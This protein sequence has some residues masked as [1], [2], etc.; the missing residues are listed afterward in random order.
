MDDIK[1]TQ[2]ALYLLPVSLSDGAVDDVLPRRNLE[3][4]SC[5]RY[6]IVENV[7]EARRF[8]RR[9]L[10][11]ADI[12]VLEFVELNRHT[13]LNEVTHWLEP[14]RRGEAMGLMSD[15]GCPGVAD[16]G[17]VVVSAARREG[18]KVVPLVG[19]SSI[20]LG[21]MGSGFN[22]QGFCFHGYLPIDERERVEA[23]RRLEIESSHRDMTQIFIETPYRNNRMLAALVST[24]RDDTGIC[25]ACELT[26]R[27]SETIVSMPA[28]KWRKVLAEAGGERGNCA[29]GK[30]DFDKRPAVFLI[31]AGRT[32]QADTES[33]RKNAYRSVDEKRRGRGR[34]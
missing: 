13:D 2:P 28:G 18:L 10:P 24:L 21:L 33:G 23:L 26:S 31:Y 17:A 3:I 32:P 29:G 22:G 4:M 27:E 5:L 9:A 6:F 1:E 16:P 12:S 8:I 34:R 19:P 11:S 25:V 30:F 7:R 14:L 15:A 20:L